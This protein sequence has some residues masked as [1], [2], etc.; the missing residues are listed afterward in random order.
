MT[1][2]PLRR[3][4]GNSSGSPAAPSGSGAEPTSAGSVRRAPDAHGPVPRRQRTDAGAAARA[5]QALALPPGRALPSRSSAPALPSHRGGVS[6]L[7]AISLPDLVPDPWAGAGSRAVLQAP[8][9]PLHRP[10]SPEREASGS[11]EA[12][13]DSFGPQASESVGMP[14]GG[15]PAPAKAVAAVTRVIAVLQ[16]IAAGQKMTHAFK[17]ANCS[18]WI[19]CFDK[20]GQLE[21]RGSSNDLSLRIFHDMLD[22][23]EGGTQGD[24]DLLS[25]FRRAERQ[26]GQR[27]WQR[28]S[29]ILEGVMEASVLLREGFVTMK[30]DIVDD[31]KY[32][33]LPHVA[34]AV[35]QAVLADGVFKSDEHDSTAKGIRLQVESLRLSGQRADLVAEWDD[36]TAAQSPAAEAAAEA[37]RPYGPQALS[38]TVDLEDRAEQATTFLE[39]LRQMAVDEE[40]LTSATG[41]AHNAQFGLC[42]DFEG[43][44]KARGAE[45]L[46]PLSESPQAAHRRTFE[47][48]REQSRV[49]IE[50]VRDRT[51]SMLQELA[52]A[53]LEIKSG[54]A[55]KTHVQDGLDADGSSARNWLRGAV[56]RF[57][58]LS[59]TESSRP[60][61][62]T[63]Q[64]K[65]DRLRNSPSQAH[66]DAARRVQ[67]ALDQGERPMGPPAARPPRP[68]G[69]RPTRPAVADT[70]GLRPYH[71]RSTAAVPA[72]DAA[73]PSRTGP[74]T[75]SRSAAATP[76]SSVGSVRAGLP[77]RAAA[78]SSEARSG[79]GAGFNAQEEVQS[80]RRGAARDGFPRLPASPA[81]EAPRRPWVPS[82]V[83]HAVLQALHERGVL[84]ASDYHEVGMRHGLSAG[85]LDEVLMRGGYDVFESRPTRIDAPEQRWQRMRDEVLGVVV[86]RAPRSPMPEGARPARSWADGAPS[87]ARAE[88]SVDLERELMGLLE[89]DDS[90]A[91]STATRPLATAAAASAP[92][93]DRVD[94]ARGL[95]TT[96]DPAR[97]SVSRRS[98]VP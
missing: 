24:K 61:V 9:S 49:T 88:E 2:P 57:G 56:D 48:V 51:A 87:V 75:R 74:T 8:Q 33:Q 78:A 40:H 22:S 65:I 17:A 43:G 73:G 92:G 79:I 5:A 90:G 31:L 32:R 97:S 55:V 72:A 89:A 52:D 95:P 13:A 62:S 67:N 16:E 82:D 64:A 36:F 42:F 3:V 85:Q 81:H 11:G 27:N 12:P 98:D 77:D 39:L 86:P 19:K 37:R 46:Q 80:R 14:G 35:A 70:T 45:F 93:G 96:P 25:D 83:M 76:A 58:F 38:H 91:G 41:K 30:K 20:N 7:Q 63:L 68:P 66:Q 4:P 53:V 71:R 6:S 44:I 69:T 54:A 15:A 50:A 60:C 18:R 23:L 21:P 1:T 29:E 47:A 28:T 84:T 94:A 10:A 34:V 26:A 59:Q